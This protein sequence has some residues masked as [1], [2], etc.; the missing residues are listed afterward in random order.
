MAERPLP[1]D[2]TPARVAAAETPGLVGL[3]TLAVAVV[4][5]AG[6]YLGREVLVPIT[7]AVLLSFLL[8][9]LAN[10]LQRAHLGRV[11]SAI[12]AVVLAIGVIMAIGGL[13]GTQVAGL[14][15][16][17]P[18]YQDTIEHKIDALRGMTIGRLQTFADT[19]TKQ[20][21][22]AT[23]PAA[24]PPKAAATPT[25]SATPAPPKPVPVEL[26]QPSLTP[27]EIAQRV[28]VPVV[29]PLFTAAIVFVVA[30]FILLQREDLRDRLI[31][32]FGSGDLHRTTVAM[33]DAARRLSRY[34][35]TQLAINTGFGVVIGCGLFLIGVPSPLLWG[36][37]AT[38]LRFVPYIGSALAALLPLVLAAAVSPGWSMVLW[39]AALYA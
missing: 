25:Q 36:A 38:L 20:M 24:T 30:I 5:V 26:Q 23:K 10:L 7:L 15:D 13:I 17:V 37:L 32:L 11:V 19:L 16:D 6:L 39:T 18:R 4:V 27:L 31:R 29:S 21:S 35:V 28:L 9:P 8:A 2:R 1:T 3:L 22:T 14:A 34:F 33:D 12:L